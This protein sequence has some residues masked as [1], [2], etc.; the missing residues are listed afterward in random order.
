MKR[1]LA[2]TLSFL[3]LAGLVAVPL[4]A[5]AADGTPISINNLS[6]TLSKNA[7]Y[8]NGK[9]HTPTVTVTDAQ[10][11]KLTQNT[12]YTVT[13]PAG[14]KKAGNYNIKVTMKGKYKG[15]KT[16]VYKVAYVSAKVA[17][18]S[19]AK[20]TVAYT[21]KKVTPAIT[22]ANPSG[23]ALKKNTDYTIT[24][25][26]T[27]KCVGKQKVTI[28][29]KGSC[30]GSKTV[31][32]TILPTIKS[33]MMVSIGNTASIGAKS[34]RTI[35]YTSSNKAVA[36]VSSKGV[37]TGVKAGTATITVK[38]GTVSR[39]IA[40]QVAKYVT[41]AK[42][43]GFAAETF[44]GSTTDDWSRPTNSYLPNGTV[45]HVVGR[46]KVGNTQYL[47]LRC[48]LRVYVDKQRE[49]YS[50]RTYVTKTS[51]GVLPDR[52]NL[53]VAA[54]DITDR[55]TEITLDTD[56][57]APFL[58]D[59]LPQSYKDPSTQN[60]V[61]TKATGTYVQ[62]RFCYAKT[63]AGA[64]DIPADHP[65]F[66]R[67]AI[68]Q[69][70]IHHDLRLYLRKTGG[71][72]GYSTSYNE[73]G[74]L[75]LRF[76]HPAQVTVGDNPYGADLTGVKILLDVGH[77]G[78]NVGA[79]G[80]STSAHPESERNLYLARL[81]KTELESMGAEVMLNRDAST[82][83]DADTRM[84]M[85]GQVKPDLC[86]AIHHDSSSSASPCGFGSYYYAPHSYGAA[87]A[88]YDATIASGIYS[89]GNRNKLS[90]HYYFVGRMTDCPVVLTENGFMTNRTDH[91]G[92]MSAATNLKKAKAIAQ[93]TA[94]Y[95]LSLRLET[96]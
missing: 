52:N 96:E 82:V 29:F 75:V 65:L 71:F 45:D 74:Q 51:F 81:L 30:Y 35:T 22:V 63:L 87:K 14:R 33:S 69:N 53:S 64:V 40:V 46:V 15:T 11:V 16:L 61:V 70:G 21:G 28:K 2:I 10:G 9:V 27:Q 79:V 77:G 80:L 8:Y 43:T 31:Y 78:W 5:A 59:V 62:I 42:V 58:V 32:Y 12:D 39:K 41:V 93:G 84:A 19:L 18:V 49:P 20:T 67:A 57:K 76:L 17:K 6:V 68:V 1:I 24:Y 23:V 60:Y 89:Y 37:V 4:P 36:K 86:I 50:D 88:V 26:T 56:W 55:A 13:Y 90:W 25:G 85:L 73:A 95:F 66:S 48:G 92:I 38:S 83:L 94:N 3:L 72:Y 44:D 7:A 54:V 47:K 91:N 34:N